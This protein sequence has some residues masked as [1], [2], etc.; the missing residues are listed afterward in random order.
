MAASKSNFI[1]GNVVEQLKQDHQPEPR[2]EPTA[3]ENDDAQ[4]I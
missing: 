3:V 2:Q 1:F 4:H